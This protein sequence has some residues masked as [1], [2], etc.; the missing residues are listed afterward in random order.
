MRALSGDIGGTHCRLAL[1]RVEGGRVELE[2][3]VR[4][5]NEEHTGLD[6]ILADFLAVGPV[7][8]A[9]CLAVAGPTDGRRVEFTNLD[10]REIGRASCRERVS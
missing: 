1:A 6:A 9:C 10:W 3:V 5:R 2:R 7:P 8:E 4:Y